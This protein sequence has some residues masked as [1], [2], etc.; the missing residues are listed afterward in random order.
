MPKEGFI[1]HSLLGRLVEHLLAHAGAKK[2]ENK[3]V[4]G[5]GLDSNT[6][7][8]WCVDCHSYLC[9]DCVDLHK[10]LKMSKNHMTLLAKSRKEH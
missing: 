5:S 1:T 4:C 2:G 8:G 10:W 6:A 3:V 9:Q 7:A